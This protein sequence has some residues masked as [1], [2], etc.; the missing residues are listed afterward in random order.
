LFVLIGGLTG[1]TFGYLMMYWC[2]AV[3]Y[4]LN[5]GGRPLNSY[6]AFV[7]ITFE[8]AILF[9]S[10]SAMLALLGF[11]GLPKPF[12][13]VFEVPEF[14]SASND[15]FWLSIR[16]LTD[17]DRTRALTLLDDAGATHVA[18]VEASP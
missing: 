6:P 5:V 15:K 1:A 12:H 13:P 16:V 7:P 4:P 8:L 10:I 14:T 2:N 9:A 11:G 18:C 17:S 3:D